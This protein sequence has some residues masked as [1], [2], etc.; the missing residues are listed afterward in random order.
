MNNELHKQLK[1][2]AYA[3]K[4]I[5]SFVRKEHNAW[6][7]CSAIIAVTTAGVLF[8]ITRTEWLIILL[9]FGIVLAAE[10]FNTAI[11]RL[12]NLVSPDYHP[13]AGD[14]KDIAAGAVLICAITAAIIGAVIFIPYF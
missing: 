7:H 1:S 10:A 2:F 4:G 8:N 9:C 12:V 11:E 14:V 13:I 6:I 5:G 3:W